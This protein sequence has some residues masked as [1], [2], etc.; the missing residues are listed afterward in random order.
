[1]GNVFVFFNVFL[2]R[3]LAHRLLSI[4]L[5]Q[6]YVVRLCNIFHVFL[7]YFHIVLYDE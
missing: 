2:E 1:M 3:K 7:S 6:F 5:E 4:F